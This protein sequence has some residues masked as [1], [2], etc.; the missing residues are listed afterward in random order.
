[1]PYKKLFRMPKPVN[2]SGRSS[3]I[4]NSFINGII[5]VVKP[6]ESE[7]KEALLILN[8]DDETISCSYCG[9]AYTEWDHLRPLVMA[10]KP[11]GYISEIHNLVPSC[12]KC[13]Q[14][15]GNKNWREWMLSDA[16]KSPKSRL[17]EDL[18]ARVLAL[19]KYELWKTPTKMNF[20]GVVGED[21]WAAHWANWQKVQDLMKESQVLAS[22]INKK[23]ALAYKAL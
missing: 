4:T 7:I 21:V 11:T 3:S 1:M 8:M 17:I 23:V 20:E 19:D 12:G 5:P 13:N 10:Q 6:T 16:P 18:D 2:I 9:D 22:E 14:S 15:K